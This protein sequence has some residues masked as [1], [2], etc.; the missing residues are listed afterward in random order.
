MVIS[1]IVEY[2]AI[3]VLLSCITGWSFEMS[4]LVG[5]VVVL[6]YTGAGGYLAVAYTDFVQSILM[7]IGLAV[8]IPVCISAAGASP[9]SPRACMPSTRPAH[10][11]A[12]I[13]I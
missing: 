7:L 5:C 8:L 12:R 11:G 2:L 13:S 10:C 3:G 9:A 4:M 6:I 1:L